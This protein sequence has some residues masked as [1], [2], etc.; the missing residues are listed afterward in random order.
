MQN[1]HSQVE[2]KDNNLNQN[3]KNTNAIVS[4]QK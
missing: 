4:K 1:R 2:T 3:I